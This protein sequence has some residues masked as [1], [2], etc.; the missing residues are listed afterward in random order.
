MFTP[1]YFA[2][3]L[4]IVERSCTA[5]GEGALKISDN[6]QAFVP[7]ALTALSLLL[8]YCFQ[9]FIDARLPVS[10]VLRRCFSTLRQFMRPASLPTVCG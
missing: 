3:D 9:L 4:S 7:S 1:V 2:C 8:S 10:L 5:E 6:I